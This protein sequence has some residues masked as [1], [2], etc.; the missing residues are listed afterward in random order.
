[1]MHIQDMVQLLPGSCSL[2]LSVTISPFPFWV[3]H[4][5]SSLA[6]LC[7]RQCFRM[8][9]F[10]VLGLLLCVLGSIYLFCWNFIPQIGIV[11]NSLSFGR[12]LYCEMFYLKLNTLP[13]ASTLEHC[14][15]L[16]TILNTGQ[17]GLCKKVP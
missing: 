1:M 14:V 5:L 13:Q 10:T 11:T 7:Q 16:D 8:L 12:K 4:F 6:G 17:F 9:S 15:N 2:L 3:F